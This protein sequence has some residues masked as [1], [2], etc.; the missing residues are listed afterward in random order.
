MPES[1]SSSR[2]RF[3]AG[4]RVV[5]CSLVCGLAAGSVALVL[6]SALAVLTGDPV[7]WHTVLTGEIAV[8]YLVSGVL[9]AG[10]VALAARAIRRRLRAIDLGGLA[11]LLPYL[12]P[13]WER[14]DAL[15]HIGLVAAAA[16]LIAVATWLLLL[17]RLSK[18]LWAAALLTAL[19]VSAALA[20]NRNLLDE[21]LAPAALAADA[22]ILLAAQALAVVCRRLGPGRTMAAVGAVLAVASAGSWWIGHDGPSDVASGGPATSDEA[23]LPHVVLLTI[24]TLRLDVFDDVA[25]NTPEGRAFVEAMDGAVFFDQARAPSPWTA[26]SVASLMTGLL[27]DEHGYGV[28]TGLG[29]RPLTALSPELPTLAEGLV[30]HGYRA[31]AIVANPLLFPGSGIDRGFHEYHALEDVGRKLPWMR[32]FAVQSLRKMSRQWMGQWIR[33]LPYVQADRVADLAE[34]RIRRLDGESPPLFLWVHWMDPHAPYV[35]H[36]GLTEDPDGRPGRYRG[37]VRFTLRQAVRVL[38]SL[39]KAGVDDQTIVIFTSDH[40]EMFARDRHMERDR[41]GETRRAGHGHSLHAEVV[42]VPL[43]IRAPQ[44]DFAPSRVSSLA[45]LSPT[46]EELLGVPLGLR[47]TSTARSLVAA[48]SEPDERALLLSGNEWGTRQR[49]L[50]L[51][52][53]K[54]IHFPDGRLPGTEA[55]DRLFDV[56][57]DPRERRDQADRRPGRVQE[58]LLRLEEEW[59]EMQTT[60][61]T[62]AQELDAETR[63]RLKALGYLE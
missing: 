27:P 34:R 28:R 2:S 63:Q 3:I 12:V 43:A 17:H 14:L 5:A 4:L 13:L 18:S 48:E 30:E 20:V 36:A 19:V 38:E 22:A 8:V 46:L 1:T 59:T 44:S 47:R 10:L 55:P 21:P 33:R 7:G 37:E 50:V 56:V 9:A 52:R 42:R 11:L 41:G 15:I 53:W 54:L 31:E 6:D 16:T 29:D 45:D 32:I 23:P 51:G 49:G 57:R 61:S 24:D 62:D 60:P 25:Q 39:D 58:L 26:P 35:R 40:G